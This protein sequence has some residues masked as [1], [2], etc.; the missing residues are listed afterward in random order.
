MLRNQH[1][2][3]DLMLIAKLCSLFG[4]GACG[5]VQIVILYI[6]NRFLLFF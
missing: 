2:D 6:P 4:Q 5:V 3:S 1:A